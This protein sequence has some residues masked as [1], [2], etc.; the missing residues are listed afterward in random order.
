MVSLL[1]GASGA[2]NHSLPSASARY[3][4][5]VG[6]TQTEFVENDGEWSTG[7]GFGLVRGDDALSFRFLVALLNHLRRLL[8]GQSLMY[9]SISFGDARGWGGSTGFW[10]K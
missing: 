10:V 3:K 4:R 7:R 1:T 9:S 6:P 2:S 5:P 8:S